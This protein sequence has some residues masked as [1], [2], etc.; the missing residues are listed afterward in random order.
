MR[1]RI[2]DVIS[3]VHD[4]AAEFAR[5]TGD[6][7]FEARLAA[8][9]ARSFVTSARFVLDE[10]FAKGLFLRGRYLLEQL[11]TLRGEALLRYRAP[12]DLLVD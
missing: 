8:G 2:Q 3:R 1:A 7:T 12:E 5:E 4:F 11:S 6:T 9:L 10:E